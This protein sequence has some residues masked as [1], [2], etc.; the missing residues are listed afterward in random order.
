MKK[1]I[2]IPIIILISAI[3]FSSC[4]PQ[5]KI[6]VE[7]YDARIQSPKII[8]V[9]AISMEAQSAV[10]PVAQLITQSI[11]IK[12]KEIFSRKEY[13]QII[14]ALA[15]LLY[16]ECRGVKSKT[17]Q[18]C[19][20]WSALDRYLSKNNKK[21]M[22]QIITDRGTFHGYHK[23]N[24]IKSNL[25]ALAKDVLDRWIRERQGE[26]DVGRVLPKG[27]VY[28]SSYKGYN[29]FRKYYKKKGQER[30]VPKHSEVYND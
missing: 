6:I 17:N 18:A 19:V 22:L 26:K 30:I 2:K 10:Q 16:G 21:T 5:P 14:I 15:K 29:R 23:R 7:F 9:K 8:E 13:E 3:F 1:I 27:Y 20:V 28:F 12:P 11:V 25:K 4:R 24:P